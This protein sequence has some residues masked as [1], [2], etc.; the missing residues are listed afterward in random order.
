MYKLSALTSLLILYTAT[1]HAQYGC[2]TLIRGDT[3]YQRCYYTTGQ[4]VTEISY[5]RSNER[6]KH[7]KIYN[8]DHDVSYQNSYGQRYGSSH[9]DLRYQTG[10]GV[11]SAHYTMQPDGGIQYTD[12]TT[13]FKPDG[14]VDHEEDYSRGNDGELHTWLKH[15]P[16]EPQPV[17]PAPKPALTPPAAAVC[18]PVPDQKELYVVNYTS[19]PLLLTCRYTDIQAAAMRLD[20]DPADTAKVG[21]YSAFHTSSD[22]LQH[23]SILVASKPRSGYQY[24]VQGIPSGASPQQYV[25]VICRKVKTKK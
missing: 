2:K 9:V 20:I 10:G 11:V 7:V 6:W 19:E 5:L 22:P 13:Y 14:T 16:E 21:V 15:M 17:V 25:M 4:L 12:V 8:K 1:V 18:Q 3:I 23:Y 24:L